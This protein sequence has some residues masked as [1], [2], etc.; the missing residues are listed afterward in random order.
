MGWK[1]TTKEKVKQ[2]RKCLFYPDCVL[3]ECVLL[4]VKVCRSLEEQKKK[5]FSLS[6]PYDNQANKEGKSR[7]KT[8]QKE[9]KNKTKEEKRRENKRQRDRK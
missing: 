7:P 4:Y 5:S 1:E 3:S 9:R 6:L 8:E 2:K